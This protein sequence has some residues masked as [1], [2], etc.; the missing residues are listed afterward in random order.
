MGVPGWA[1]PASGSAVDLLAARAGPSTTIFADGSNREGSLEFTLLTESQR[2]ESLKPQNKLRS[3][4]LV[5]LILIVGA[6]IAWYSFA[7]EKNDSGKIVLLGTT[8]IRE[9]HLAFRVGDRIASMLVD[10]GDAVTKGQLLASLDTT[11]LESE[12]AAAEASADAS[13][14]T[15]ERLVDGSRPEEISRGRAELAGA[16]ARLADATINLK[17]TKA[18]FVKGAASQRGLDTAQAA[19]DEAAAL[20]ESLQATLDLLIA[21]PRAEDIAV[22]KAEH[23]GAL[24]RVST[25]QQHLADAQLI[26]PHAGIIRARLHEPGEIVSATSPV[27]LL[28]ITDP[29]WVRVYLDEVDLGK[30]VLGMKATITVDSDPGTSFD[31]WLGSISPTAEFTPKPVETERLRTSLVYQARVF[32]RNPGGV[33]KLGMP[34]TVT[35]TP[36]ADVVGSRTGDEG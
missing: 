7:G 13:A 32:V 23:R 33:F 34:A 1:C 22:A 30:V 12:L 21:G 5:L 3:L 25:A 24:A 29:L 35:L 11:L 15:L 2:G 31:G 14:Q 4:L 20:V 8:D 9:A 27:L 18:A 10:E 28:S 6:A 17:D 26:A 36:G 16:K 19:H